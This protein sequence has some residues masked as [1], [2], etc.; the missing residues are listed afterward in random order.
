MYRLKK[1]DLQILSEYTIKN[2]NTLKSWKKE[3][4]RIQ[5]ENQDNALYDDADVSYSPWICS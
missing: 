2:K 5:K 1:H 3:N 4:P